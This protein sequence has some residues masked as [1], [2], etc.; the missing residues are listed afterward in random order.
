MRSKVLAVLLLFVFA[1]P[2][3]AQYQMA[4]PGYR[5]EFPR[6]HFNHPDYKTE[7]W[8]YTGNLTASD[9]HKFGYELTFFRQAVSRNQ[10][11]PTDWDVR[12]LYLA[13][14]A[15]S[16]LSGGH[17][18]HTERLNR[19]G[20]G[21]AGASLQ[22]NK[23][24]N[25]NWQVQWID[26]K[27][28]LEAVSDDFALHFD[29]TSRKPPVIHGKNGVSQKSAG[30]GHA[31]HYISFTRLL[32]SGS[33]DLNGKTYRVDG[34]SWMDHEFFSHRIDEDQSGWDWLSLQLDDNTELMLYRLRHK[35]GSVDPFSSGTYVDASGKSTFLSDTDFNMQPGTETYTSPTTHGTYPI[36]WRVTIPSLGMDLQIRTALRSQEMAIRSI[37]SLS[38]WEGAI[39]ISGTKNGTALS[40]VGYLEMTGYARPVDSERGK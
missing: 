24:W 16:D 40:G 6:D 33:I 20:P 15:L 7:W 27:Q 9:G 5:Y 31:S 19:S 2:S 35:D 29:M 10:K 8:Y 28:R 1:V 11:N 39:T 12:D 36:A 38:Y 37:A 18:Y 26:G 14:L 25:G 13:H 30:I 22:L 32:T 34:T 4:L 17:F 21:L 3:P 23:V